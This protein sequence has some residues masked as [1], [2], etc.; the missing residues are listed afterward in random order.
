[1]CN[2]SSMYIDRGKEQ[3]KNRMILEMHKSGIPIETIAKVARKTVNETSK[4][5]DN[6]S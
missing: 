6:N 3:E 2:I 1:M 4:I 5:I